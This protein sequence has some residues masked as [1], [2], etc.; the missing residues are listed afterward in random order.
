MQ[1]GLTNAAKHS[2]ARRVS[3]TLHFER[4]GVKLVVSDDGRGAGEGAQDGDFGLSALKERVEALGGTLRWDDPPGGGFAL[5][6]KLP[7]TELAKAKP[8]EPP[9]TSPAARP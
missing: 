7:E 2:D 9:A 1:E 5:E 6:A 8:T 3:A 4:Y